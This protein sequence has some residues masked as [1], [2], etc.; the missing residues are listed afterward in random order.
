MQQLD[1]AASL[2]VNS[3]ILKIT[4]LTGHK[5]ISGYPEG[6]RM[7]VNIKWY[8]VSNN[9][10]REDGAYGPLEVTLDGAAQI[11]NTLLDLN[12]TNTKIYEAHMAM[13]QEWASQLLDL[14]YSAS[15]PL[16]FDREAGNVSYTLGDLANQT[17]GSYHETF[18]FVLNNH[19]AADNRIPPYGFSYNEARSRNSLPVPAEQYGSPGPGGTYHYYDTLPLNPPSGA[20]YATIQLMYQPTS[21]EYIQFLYLANNGQN[22]FLGNEGAKLLEAWLATGMAEPYVMAS[23]TWGQPS[24]PPPPSCSMPGNPAG[25]T[26]VGGKRLVT[27]NWTASDPAPLSGYRVYYDQS[28]K[29]QLRASVGH[30]VLTY[31]DTGLTRGVTYCY[32]VTAWTDCNGNGIFDPGVDNESAPSI[33]ACAVPTN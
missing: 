24:A 9:L 1:L 16:S 5:L 13:T 28:G 27:L 4:N 25:L 19:V 20:V 29:M 3:N 2:E 31:R 18:H 32:V 21:W 14:G 33:K 8:G 7:W 11:V 15:M 26:A 12:G 6:R 23:A 30:D 22:A 10:L 17:P